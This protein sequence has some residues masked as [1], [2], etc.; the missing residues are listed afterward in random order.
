MFATELATHVTRSNFITT[1]SRAFDALATGEINRAAK[2]A[3]SSGAGSGSGAAAGGSSGA[4]G[5][6]TVVYKITEEYLSQI[7]RHL[8]L[9][10]DLQIAIAVALTH[11]SLPEVSAEGVKTLRNRVQEMTAAS[12][13]PLTPYVLHHVLAVISAPEVGGS[14]VKGW[15]GMGY[16]AVGVGMCNDCYFGGKAASREVS[17]FFFKLSAARGGAPASRRCV[18]HHQHVHLCWCVFVCVR[19]A[20]QLFTS[21]PRVQANCLSA[22]KAV[23]PTVSRSLFSAPVAMP[24]VSVTTPHTV[25][26]TRYGSWASLLTCAGAWVSRAIGR[27][28]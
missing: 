15:R 11:S 17:P 2:T 12:C 3:G 20:L 16:D 5:A 14:A 18:M 26:V 7:A 19:V 13:P 25:D 9:T 28:L 1:I 10:L 23:H 22:I 8:K 24:I 4:S 27:L 6:G 21:A